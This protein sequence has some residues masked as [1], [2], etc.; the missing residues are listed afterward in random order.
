MI[1]VTGATGLS[2]SAILREFVRAGQPVRALVRDRGKAEALAHGSAVEVALGDMSKPETLG[3]AFDGIERALMISGANLQMVE[4]QCTFID[5]AQRAGVRHIVKLSGLGFLDSA[6]PT[7]RFGKMHIDIERHLER[8][9]L[10]WTHL[11]PGQFMQ[12]Y[13][14]EAPTIASEGMIRLPLGDAKLAPIDVE[15]IAKIAFRVVTSEGHEGKRY[16]MTGPEALTMREAAERL[17]QALGREVRYVDVDPEEK[18]K[19]LL[20]AGIPPAFADGIDELFAARRDGCSKE[21]AVHLATHERFG[22]TPT[23]FLEFARRNADVFRGR[24]AATH[25]WASGWQAGAAG[26]KGAGPHGQA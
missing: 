17:S 18:R 23:T 25:L 13:L 24:T 1:L 19:S 26:S 10:R 20:A 6:P 8:S 11:C 3:A 4:T 2:G 14:R 22:V 7:F 15:D 12:V 21:S 16:E 5:A 9:G